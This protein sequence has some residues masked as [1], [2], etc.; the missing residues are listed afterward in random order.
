MKVYV[1]FCEKDFKKHV[2]NSK[3]K[4][5][6]SLSFLD[7]NSTDVVVRPRQ[8]GKQRK[9]CQIPH[10]ALSQNIIHKLIERGKWPTMKIMI[11]TLSI[12]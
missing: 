5:N 1:D 9:C 6:A 7:D 8:N 11:L 10:S 4:V 12:N 3:G 2:R